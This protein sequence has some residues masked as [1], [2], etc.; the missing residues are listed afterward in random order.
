MSKER[1]P[2]LKLFA[3]MQPYYPKLAISSV[4]SI[5]NKIADLMPPVMVAWIIDNLSG[6]PP[7][8][9]VNLLG[10]AD[11]ITVATALALL[12]MFVFAFESFFEW[13]YD[14]GFQSLAQEVQHDLRLDAYTKMQDREM[15]FFERE[16]T[17]NLMA[18]LNNDVNQLQTFLNTG[19]NEILQ[20]IVLI[21]FCG[22]VLVSVNLPLA[23][24]GLVPVPIIIVA[25]FFYKNLMSPKYKVIRE[26]VG[27]VSN[28][29]ENNI[30]GISVIKSFTAEK[31][32]RDR[33]AEE[34][35]YY[36]DKNIDAIRYNTAYVP[37]IRMFV[38]V[39]F[40]LTMLVGSYW[41]LQGKGGLTLGS[42]TLFAMMIQRLLW[43][44]TRLGRI[45]DQY[46]R[47]NASARRVFALLDADKRIKEIEEPFTCTRSL[48][49]LSVQD[50]HFSYQE[51]LP[52]V[53][54]LSIEI[55]AGETI[56]IAGST[57][58]G[59]TTLIKL[60]LRLYDL[61]R[62]SI[63]VDGVDI[64]DW[65][66]R[67]LR[68]NIGLVSQDVYLFHGSV[69][70]NIA[71]GMEDVPLEAVIGASKRAEL[72][73]FVD[74][75]PDAYESIIGERGIKLSGGQRQRLSIARAI[76]KDAPILILDE[77]TSAVDNE[78]EKSIQKNLQSLTKDRTAIII[79]HRLSTIRNADN[80]LVL[81]DGQLAESGRHD[82]LLER[83]KIY[84]DLWN[85][86]LGL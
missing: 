10:T 81:Q 43:P 37:I 18:M 3:Y 25:S 12:I 29:L 72:H 47:A 73:D 78:T 49:R 51:G 28:R 42:I 77:A 48:G 80:I 36:R 60:F 30:S 71:Y 21:I 9:V 86:Q 54:G 75:L 8:W 40:T 74:A 20:M 7:S 31:F 35:A 19:F 13:L 2:M 24:L 82:E 68:Q 23:M 27:Y 67:S 53:R 39:G 57:G 41:L 58:S 65:S 50:A 52:I 61:D 33:L 85:V 26:A 11:P 63:S 34:S 16:R 46:E 59:K 69:R 84:A 66:L 17:G 38:A 83:G 32:E 56:G 79:A 5:I 4:Y 55:A 70:D 44:I 1:D 64:R 15:A 6:N 22:F 14:R 76:L 45:F 62:G